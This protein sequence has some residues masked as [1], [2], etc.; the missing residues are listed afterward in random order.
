MWLAGSLQAV[1]ARGG[2]VEQYTGEVLEEHPVEQGAPGYRG[3][4][5]SEWERTLWR[6]V[7]TVGERVG[8]SKRVVREVFWFYRCTRRLRALTGFKRLGLC[9]KCVLTVYYV[10]ARVLGD[11]ALAERVASELGLYGSG[12]GDPEVERYL[13]TALQYASAIYAVD[14]VAA[15]ETVARVHSGLLPSTVYE[16][17]KEIALELQRLLCGRSPRV[18]AAVALKLA[19]DEVAPGRRG[20]LPPS[21]YST[22]G[23]SKHVVSSLARRLARLL[24]ARASSRS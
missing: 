14:P 21:I 23:V 10:V 1:R 17:A 16:R 12:A 18:V 19:L 8:A 3:V 4:F 11:V 5:V 20:E 9:E 22:L 24:P 6:T 15:V 13:T 7:C 2:L